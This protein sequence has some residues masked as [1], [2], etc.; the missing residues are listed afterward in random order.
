MTTFDQEL[1][2]RYVAAGGDRPDLDARRLARAVFVRDTIRTL[3][4]ADKKF[5]IDPADNGS[6]A[7]LVD[8]AEEHLEHI[9]D[10]VGQRSVMASPTTGGD[11]P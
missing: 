5:G 2:G 8:A 3:Y 6:L 1:T 10:D 11:T 9:A 7:E 4:N